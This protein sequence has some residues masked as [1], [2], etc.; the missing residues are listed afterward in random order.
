VPVKISDY[1]KNM[2]HA[3]LDPTNSAYS[4]DGIPL[5]AMPRNRILQWRPHPSTLHWSGTHAK[6]SFA[7]HG[8][9]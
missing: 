3:M 2:Q 6:L 4:T 9:M 8:D 5:S 7:N 1:S